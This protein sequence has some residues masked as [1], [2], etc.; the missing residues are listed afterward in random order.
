MPLRDKDEYLSMR[1]LPVGACVDF[2]GRPALSRRTT[3]RKA[4]GEPSSVSSSALPL[5]NPGIIVATVGRQVSACTLATA[6]SQFCALKTLPATCVFTAFWKAL[7]RQ[8]AAS[9]RM[10]FG[11]LGRP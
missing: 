8:L 5:G 11:C 3:G 9:V 1:M 10:S 2:S 6:L 4:V 7:S